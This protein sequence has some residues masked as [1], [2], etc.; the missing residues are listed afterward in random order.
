MWHARAR[1]SAVPWVWFP[2]SDLE[3]PIQLLAGHSHL[4][5]GT[6]L[7]GVASQLP[8]PLAPSAV[9][10]SFSDGVE[11]DAELV[12]GTA[13]GDHAL[14]VPAFRTATGHPVAAAVWPVTEISTDEN[15]GQVLIKI[16]RRL[17]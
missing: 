17:G 2:V 16:G 11:V 9:L 15:E 6:R 7:I 8:L 1:L 14:V 13:P 5:P 4:F 12:S 10:L 3:P